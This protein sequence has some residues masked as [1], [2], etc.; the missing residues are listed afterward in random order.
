MDDG[1]SPTT[2]IIIFLIL[3]LVDFIVFGFIAAMQNLN[4]TAVEKMAK[5]GN[6]R[7]A[8]L[9]K[10]IDKTER[11]THVCQLLILA[12]HMLLGFWLVPLWRTYFSGQTDSVALSICWQ[13]V[14]F[15]LL[16]FLVLVFGIYTP[17]KVAARKPDVWAMKLAAPVHALEIIFFPLIWLTDTFSNLFARVFGVD[18]LSDTDDVTEEEII[19][20]VNEGHEQG[21]LLASEAEMIHNI[22]E[23]GDK[24]A[25]DIMIHRKNM[26][27]LDG[28]LTFYEALQFMRDNNYSRFPVYLEDIDN[29]IGVLHIKDALDLS[30]EQSAYGRPVHEIDGLVRDVDFIPETRNIN[31]LFSMMQ[32]SKSHMV[33]VVDEYGQTS[34]I[35]AMEDIIEEIVG[36]IEDEHDEEQTMIEELSEGVYRVDGMASFDEV[37]ETLGIQPEDSDDFETLNGFLISLIDKIPNDHEEFSITAY[38]YLFEILSVENKMI[39]SVRITRDFS[40]QMT[41][42]TCQNKETMIE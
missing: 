14:A 12:A 41:Q 8:L 2:G 39:Q 32:R 6:K 3:I 4:E 15:L 5:E 9:L 26:I 16:I 1:G 24:E 13:I 21:M 17:E 27:A 35:V 34:G 37:M 10:Y 11:Y 20:M 31:T 23:F 33:I 18:P 40:Q 25:K 28:K 19:S 29:I 38:G 36:N 7:A 22:F 30:L 42:E